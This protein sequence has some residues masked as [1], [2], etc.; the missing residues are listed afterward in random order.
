MSSNGVNISSLLSALGSTSSGID[1]QT[2]VAQAISNESGPL[3]QMQ[4]QQAAFTSDTSDINQIETDIGTLQTA[5]SGLSDP[6]GALNAMTTTS[7]ASSLV[8]ASAES[9]TVAGTHVVAVNNLASTASWYSGSVATSSTALA[10]GSFTFQVGSNAPVQVNIGGASDTLDQLASSINGLNAGVTA[11]VVNDSSGSRLAIVSNSSGAASNFTISGATGLSFTQAAKGTDASLTVDG[12]PVDSA[13]N[14]VTGV[15]TG[16]TFNLLSASASST[17]NI[18]IAPDASQVSSGISSFV[19]AYNTVIADVNQEF[20]LGSN[21]AEGPLSGDPAVSILQS[22]LLASGSY[23]SGGSGISTLG[24]LGIT[25]NND[26]TLS[27]NTS[28]LNSAV[29]NNYSGVQNFFQG[30][31]L[32]G[33]ASIL[34]TQL[35]TLTDPTDGAFTVDLKSISNQSSDLQSQITT[36]QS[37]LSAQTTFLTNEY[38][39]ADIALQQLPIEEQQINAELGNP[40]TSTTG[41]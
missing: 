12:I 19:S 11:S 28:T 9:G 25:M 27:L 39:Q 38:D 35:A 26:G 5:L 15:V 32:N 6:V 1:V 21:G 2:A 24:D 20:A 22:Q 29:E 14:T 16:V 41:G 30:A 37:Y 13:S 18:T 36:F 7:S 3:T 23:T 17:A 40:T 31:A 8:T 4:N 33:F 10:T 34:S